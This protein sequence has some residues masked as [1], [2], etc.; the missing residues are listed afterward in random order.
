[1]VGL[2]GISFGFLYDG[3]LTLVE[4]Q[5]LSAV[6]VVVWSALVSFGLW[7]LVRSLALRSA[8]SAA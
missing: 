3:Q 2:F 6:I 7:L 1:M 4:V 8:H 5:L